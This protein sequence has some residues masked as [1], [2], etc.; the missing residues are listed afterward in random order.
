MHQQDAQQRVAA[1]QAAVGVAALGLLALVLV[2]WGWGA[3]GALL[4]PEDHFAPEHVA[5]AESYARSA[6]AW[7]WTSLAVSLIAAAAVGFTR[8]GAA[9]VERLPGRWWTTVMLAVLGWV[10][11]QKV[12]TFGPRVGAWQLRR[13]VGISTQEWDG[14]LRDT[15]VAWGLEV[16]TL[17]VLVLVGV[18][19]ARRLPRSWT[20]VAGAVVAILVAG[21]SYVHP[22]V[23]EPLTNDF[24]SLPRGE[25]RDRITALASA[26]GVAVTDVVVADASRR[27]ST[28]NA[29]VSGF[30][31]T[32]RV[33][34]YDNLVEEVP[35]EEVLVVVAHE[36]AHARH[37]DVL[38]G[39]TLGAVGAFAATGVLGLI[40][41]RRRRSGGGDP[42]SVPL[43]LGLLAVGMQVTA[44][45]H[46]VISRAVEAR[47]DVA[48]LCV[49]DDRGAFAAVQV[50]LASRSLSD[51][52]PPP[53]AHWWWG[54]H[55]TTMERISM[56]AE[57]RGCP[58]DVNR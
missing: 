36:L 25:L 34:L 32:R 47:A 37:N 27:T 51:L 15:A 31:A 16:M 29:W 49:V 8:V 57:W 30:G 50:R 4:P 46:N 6:R 13:D 1:T 40:V 53:L 28:L 3:E 21:V 20:L 54:S 44:P 33:V 55:P 7:S 35:E 22:V 41:G 38:V 45:V 19:L 26:E 14:F 5:A 9:V 42:R 10:T 52:T 39:T 12:L 18:G 48:A 23:V 2:P 43:V 11:L 58:D 56:V 17:W 24:A